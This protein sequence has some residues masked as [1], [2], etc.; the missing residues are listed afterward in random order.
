MFLLRRGVSTLY[1]LKSREPELAIIKPTLVQLTTAYVPIVEFNR[2]KKKN[3]T[4]YSFMDTSS[5]NTQRT[6]EAAV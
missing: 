5:N 3:Q 2:V 6:A 1:R 4:V